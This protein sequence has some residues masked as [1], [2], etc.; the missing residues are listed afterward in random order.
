VTPQPLPVLTMPALPTITPGTTDITVGI[1][2]TLTLAAGSYRKITV[3][4]NGTLILTGGLYQVSSLDIQTN[5]RVF[6]LAAAEVRVK[7][8]IAADAN[9]VIAPDASAP[10]LQA[11]QIVFYV[12]GAD[13]SGQPVV[14]VGPN[15]TVKAN[16]YAPNGTVWLKSSTTGTGAFIGKQV[17][18]DTSVEL[19]LK[20]AF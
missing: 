10:A 1:N 11:S 2:Q 18:I 17:N 4:T 15:G 14:Q 12:E 7:N 20:S 6:F 19:T 5:A 13:S 8:G 9:S 16:I 3:K